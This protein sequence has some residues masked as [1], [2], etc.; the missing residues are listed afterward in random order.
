MRRVEFEIFFSETMLFVRSENY[1]FSTKLINGKYP[2]YEKIIPKDFEI[3]LKLPKNDIIEAIRLIN[4]L[5][6]KM[7]ITIDSNGI[8]FESM[9]MEESESASTQL[10]IS[11]DMKEE[12]TIGMDSK[13]VL[14]F[15]SFVQGNEFEILLNDA[16]LPFLL[17]DENYSTIVMPVI[18]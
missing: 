13:Y 9:S 16:N 2:D 15:L 5:A 11:L 6:T 1:V 8:S 10:E 14:D 17:Q 4:P 18:I 12:L 7:K 3:K